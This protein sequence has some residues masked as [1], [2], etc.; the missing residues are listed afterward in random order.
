[1]KMNFSRRGDC[2]QRPGLWLQLPMLRGPRSYP[3][4]RMRAVV[5]GFTLP[6]VILIVLAV[7]PSI[8][9]ASAGVA[10]PGVGA[11]TSR[12]DEASPAK[13]KRTLAKLTI[14]FPED[15]SIFPPGITAPTFLWL[16]NASSNSWELTV[17]FADHAPSIHA[18]S[19]GVRMEIGAIDPRC[20]APSNEP[21]KL[22]PRQAASWTWK[23]DETTWKTIHQH[24]LRGP[25][26][27][28]VTGMH[29]GKPNSAVS[30]TVFTTSKDPVGAP[31]FYR[32]VPLMPATNTHGTV[33]PLAP[34]EGHLINW[35]IRGVRS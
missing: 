14:D 35:P 18:T 7:M 9:M 29:D 11:A 23:P 26:T 10:A 21:P 19:Q 17:S 1:M 30:R 27:F 22:S 31:I 15:G 34:Q 32:D 3:H 12:P 5:L 13:P 2:S 33:Q 8:R 24:S 28:I 20:V 4:D 25:A 6:V 16:D